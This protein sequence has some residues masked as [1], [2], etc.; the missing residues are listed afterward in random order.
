MNALV[1]PQ[2][3][4]VNSFTAKVLRNGDTEDFNA[5]YFTLELKDL[6]DLGG[7]YWVF[8]A[9]YTVKVDE[10]RV[11][12]KTITLALPEES[13]SGQFFIPDEPKGLYMDYTDTSDPEP[14]IHTAT[15]GTVI[16]TLGYK[17]DELSTITGKLD[18]TVSDTDGQSFMISG[19]LAY[20]TSVI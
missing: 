15:K 13:K 5:K 7:N 16:L 6:P 3:R 14:Y 8:S 1:K 12:K 2:I 11:D 9:E 10:N 17:R 19:D 18:V 4:L 20:S